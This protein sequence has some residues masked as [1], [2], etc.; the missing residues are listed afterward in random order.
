[1]PRI[2]LSYRRSDSMAIA[3]RIFDRLIEHFG[4]KSVFMDVDDIPF[5]KDFRKHI[6]DVLKECEV[7]IAI[8]GPQ[9]LGPREDSLPRIGERIDPI[10]IEIQTAFRRQIRVI[11]VLVEGAR[12]PKGSEL[13]RGIRG[14]A[15]LNAVEVES[16]RDFNVH[17]NRLIRATNHVATVSGYDDHSEGDSG[18]GLRGVKRLSLH[19]VRSDNRGDIPQRASRFDIVFA[20]LFL[21]VLSLMLAH[22]LIV[23]RFDLS[24]FYLRLSG[25]TFSMQTVRSWGWAILVDVGVGLIAVFCMLT[26]VHFIDAVPIMPSNMVDWRESIEYLGIIVLA[27]LAGN[28][29]ARV[30]Q[31]FR[32]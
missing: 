11:P 20:Y 2:C 32:N 12:M 10:R 25:F 7:L 9:W 29:L 17:V 22:Y 18:T 19:N 16:G 23:I 15:F 21:P 27:G 26:I 13:P 31:H 24:P 1:M 28:S 8:V 4:T 6:D 30:W 3:G 14:F 5:G